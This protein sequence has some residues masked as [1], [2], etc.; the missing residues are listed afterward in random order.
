MKY[1]IVKIIVSYYIIYTNKFEKP[2]IQTTIHGF[3]QVFRTWAGAVQNLMERRAWVKTWGVQGGGGLKTV[4][5][6]T[7]EGVHL[8]VKLPTISLETCKFTENELLHTGFS[9]ILARF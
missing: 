3:P 6:G 9:S 7:C 8:L 4:L 5:K 1:E 2:G